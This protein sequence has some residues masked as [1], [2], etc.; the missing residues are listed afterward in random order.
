MQFNSIEFLFYFLPVFL[1]FYFIFPEEARSAVLI[2][3]SLAFYY[4]A[5]NRNI[6]WVVLLAALTLLS[7][8]AGLTLRKPGSGIFLGAYLVLLVEILAFFKVYCGG[9]YLPAGMSF[10]LFQI[11]AYLI[12][13]YR[14][15][16]DA[17]RSLL[18]YSAQTVMFPKL[19]SGPLVQPKFL[20]LQQWFC[21]PSLK[22]VHD[23]LQELIVG[24]AMKVILANRLGGLWR[25]AGV[26]GYENLSVPFAWMAILAF[27]LQLYFDFYGYSLMAIGLGRMLG[28]ELPRNFDDPYASKTVSEFYRRWHV[29]LGT[30]FR[31]YI[32]IP[33]GGNRRGTLRTILNLAVVWLL[34]GL[35]HGIG[36]NY[37]AW[38][39]IL[40]FLII[41]E[42]LW[43][44]KILKRGKVI[45]HIYVVFAILLSWVP[46]A[47]GQWNQV[48]AL[49]GRLLGFAGAAT[50]PQDFLIWGHSYGTLLLAGI[51]FATPL[52]R[53]LWEKCRQSVAVDLLLVVL[54]WI[55]VYFIATS[56]Q[57]PFLYFTY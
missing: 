20:G 27:A 6:L 30:W 18:R 34:T 35:W 32:Y 19:Q 22:G 24:L 15:K 7:F 54:F 5:S 55:V 57:D 2:I 48:A 56:A 50:N 43:L 41:N 53:R 40:L 49:Y 1:V 51:F 52:P 17:E 9:K 12:D 46:F 45:G 25:Q 4:L 44:G 36:G 8:L 23:G 39:G 42:R 26:Q 21:S 29:T 13:V 16:A 37:L 38:A 10:Y 47:V 14:Q 28:Y 31:E 33:L 11:A 3:G